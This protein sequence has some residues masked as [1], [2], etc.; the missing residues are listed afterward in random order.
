VL[1][2][3]LGEII[4]WPN[5][6]C[7]LERFGFGGRSVTDGHRHWACAVGRT[8]SFRAMAP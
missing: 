1:L 3:L 7:C 4:E 6:G 2:I 8:A 5:V